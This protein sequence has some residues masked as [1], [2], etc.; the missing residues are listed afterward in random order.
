MITSRKSAYLNRPQLSHVTAVA[1]CYQFAVSMCLV[2][3][4]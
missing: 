3:F 2:C 1:S 4:I